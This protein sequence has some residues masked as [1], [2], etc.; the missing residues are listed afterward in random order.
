MRF[1]LYLGEWQPMISLSTARLVLRPPEERD[2]EAL[3][4]MDADPEVMRY[5]GSGA[6]I[7]P[8]RVRALR[9]VSR[10]REQWE[11]QGFGM[12]S[13]IVAETGEYAG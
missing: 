9:A 1:R 10:W 7:P 13:V 4:A 11:E 12:C 8:D 6:I 3:M 5:I 2:V